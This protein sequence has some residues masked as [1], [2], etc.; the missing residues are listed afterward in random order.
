MHIKSRILFTFIVAGIEDDIKE[1]EYASPFSVHGLI[2]AYIV[3]AYILGVISVVLFIQVRRRCKIKQSNDNLRISSVY[4]SSADHVAIVNSEP[5][6]AAETMSLEPATRPLANEQ[7]E[8]TSLVG[9][10]SEIE[11]GANAYDYVDPNTI[12]PHRLPMGAS[13]DGYLTPIN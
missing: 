6:S 1:I 11:D 13:R 7:Q 4:S 8:Y 2:A 10:G 3:V 12:T 9:A 5:R